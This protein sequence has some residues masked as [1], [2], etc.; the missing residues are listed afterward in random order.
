[1]STSGRPPG[2][3][4]IDELLAQVRDRI[5]RVRPEEVAARVAA[6]ALLVDTRPWEQRVR[7]GAVP[8]ALV[9]DR[10]VLEWRLDPA[11]P[12]RLPQ[13]TGYDLEVVVL[14]NQGYSSSLVADTLRT[15]GLHR[16]VDVVGGFE[17]WVAGGLPVRPISGEG[18]AA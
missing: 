12:D 14:C 13:V 11:S 1:V 7:D 2:A 5:G 16:A 17:A 10:N 18:H 8:G 15:L 6:G 3:R 4:S 9:V